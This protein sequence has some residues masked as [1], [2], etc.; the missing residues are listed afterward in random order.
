MVNS[1]SDIPIAQIISHEKFPKTTT[2]Q[3]PKINNTENEMS[4]ILANLKNY[5]ESLIGL[6]KPKSAFSPKPAG[7]DNKLKLFLK[8]SPTREICLPNDMTLW[9]VLRLY[10]S[11]TSAQFVRDLTLTVQL[12]DG[13]GIQ[14]TAG[15]GIVSDT[16]STEDFEMLN[17][18]AISSPLDEFVKCDG[19][20]TLAER[21]PILMPFI[22]VN[23]GSINLNY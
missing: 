21:L 23:F 20:I 19:L 3:Q 17:S 5:S 10:L 15:D 8:V 11:Q 2:T 13:N 9:N 6:D 4:D 14:E 18:Y 22:Q 7:S 12:T 16:I 1:I